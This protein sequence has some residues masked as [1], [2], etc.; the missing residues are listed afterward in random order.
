MAGKKRKKRG[1]ELGSV[2]AFLKTLAV[3]IVIFVIFNYI[4]SMA[5]WSMTVR[6][7]GDAVLIFILIGSWLLLTG[8]RQK[9]EAVYRQAA[10]R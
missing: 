8:K 2:T 1:S 10:Y 4:C 3:V 6:Q 9:E 7:I 5:N